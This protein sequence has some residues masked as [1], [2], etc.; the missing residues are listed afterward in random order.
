MIELKFI[1]RNTETECGGSDLIG[2]LYKSVFICSAALLI[3]DEVDVDA[4]IGQ[5]HFHV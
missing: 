1:S 3:K 4:D 2:L 5:G